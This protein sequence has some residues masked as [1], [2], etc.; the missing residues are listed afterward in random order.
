MLILF[1]FCV[2]VSLNLLW[3]LF[4]LWRK[5]LLYRLLHRLLH[6]IHRLWLNIVIG[7]DVALDRRGWNPHHFRLIM[8]HQWSHNHRLIGQLWH[9]YS[10]V[11][12]LVQNDRNPNGRTF[13]KL[14]PCIEFVKYF[15][16]VT[17]VCAWTLVGGHNKIRYGFLQLWV[18]VL[19]GN[20][21]TTCRK[22]VA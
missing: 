13:A 6:K 16:Q 10:Q 5:L 11:N 3:Y 12:S 15:K 20:S 22:T 21:L 1:H 17:N 14:V 19:I 2:A 8:D 4:K 18:M 7:I 9:R